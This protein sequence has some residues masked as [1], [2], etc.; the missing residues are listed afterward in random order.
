MP[1]QTFVHLINRV[2][3]EPEKCHYRDKNIRG[4]VLIM[5]GRALYLQQKYHTMYPVCYLC[6]RVR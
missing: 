6:G 1:S 3:D 5:I 2:K 4:G